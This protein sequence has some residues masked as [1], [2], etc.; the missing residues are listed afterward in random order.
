MVFPEESENVMV[1]CPICGWK[2]KE[3][4]PYGFETR[5][6]AKCPNCGA[7]ERHRLY[8]LYLKRKIPIYKNLK[9]LHFSPEKCLVG[10]LKSYDNVEYLSADI[11]PNLAMKKEDITNI[12]FEDNS[13]DIIICSHI[14]EHIVEDI[15]AMQEL[16]RIL[17]PG[18]F[19]LIQVPIGYEGWKRKT[20]FE[21][22]SV[23]TPEERLKVFKHPG[24]VRIYGLDYKNKLKKAGFK[25]KIINFT[26]EELIKRFALRSGE[27]LYVC[28]K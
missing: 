21:D 6:N 27:N 24:H 13:F 7:L 4:L 8:Y 10:F 16:F 5:K 23:N 22:S 14:L 17:K 2:G 15:K 18:G 11:N 26:N 28:S 25:V 19:A 3:F 12:S 20:T 9:L 1:E